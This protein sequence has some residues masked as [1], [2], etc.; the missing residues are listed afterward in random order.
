MFPITV[1]WPPG[2]TMKGV[3]SDWPINA[4][5]G[6]GWVFLIVILLE[7]VLTHNE[8]HDSFL[9]MEPIFGLVINNGH[10]TIHYFIH[11]HPISFYREG[12]HV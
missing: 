8:G 6:S 9:R 5:L 7:E 10:G 12:M 4:T 11:D 3:L 1:V 2:T